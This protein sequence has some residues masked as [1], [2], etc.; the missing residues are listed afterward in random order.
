MQIGQFRKN[1]MKTVNTKAAKAGV[2]QV[3]RNTL[4]ANLS[5][6][7]VGLAVSVGNVVQALSKYV[8]GEQIK[9]EMKDDALI[10]M[11]NVGYHL[12]VLARLLKVKLPSS[13][14]KIKL[15]G[16]RTAA[17]IE[18]Q[19]VT[20]DLL[21]VVAHG[22][23]DAPPT[24]TVKKMVVM[25]NK[26]G[27]KEERDTQVIDVAQEA[28]K[29]HERLMALFGM[30][31]DAVQLYWKLCFDT[32]GHPPVIAFENKFARMQKEFP[33]IEFDTTIST[34]KPKAE[35]KAA[36][37]VQQAQETAQASA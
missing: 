13:T 17:L 32:F 18:L 29:D 9:Q 33:G 4:K 10:E 6:A 30:V 28:A 15:V 26:G 27:A 37:P 25:P 19:G 3:S 22:L 21:E 24:M 31:T 14:K 12:V 20:T 5:H 16:T 2:R 8:L 34:P 23:F 11:G 35:K 36:A 7:G 1:V